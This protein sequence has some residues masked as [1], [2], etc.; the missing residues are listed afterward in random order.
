MNTYTFPLLLTLALLA[1]SPVKA[2]DD[3]PVYSIKEDAPRVGSS[4][5]QDR[6]K[7]FNV[8]I[9]LPYE[10]LPAADRQRFHSLYE[11]LPEG[12]EPPF[13]LDGL[14]II[15]KSLSK[16]HNKFLD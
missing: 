9:N 8:A 1:S 5:R 13:P 3:K 12:D 15:V 10:R 4:I 16:A 2:V 14:Q 6:A 7:G 11:S